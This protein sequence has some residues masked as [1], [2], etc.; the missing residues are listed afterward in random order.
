MKFTLSIL[1]HKY[2]VCQLSAKTALP[3]WATGDELL[4]FVRTDEELSIVCPSDGVPQGVLAEDG[5]RAVKVV[6]PLDFSLL[7]VLAHLTAVLAEAGV[8]IFALSTYN[9][10]YLLLKGECLDEAVAALR[11]AG[12][13]VIP[14]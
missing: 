9:T 4:A 14:K 5:W 12:H 6:G 10:D 13:R 8:S 7:G 1:Q 2:A 3:D 11:E